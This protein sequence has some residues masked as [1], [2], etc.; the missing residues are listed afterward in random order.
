MAAISESQIK[1]LIRLLSDDSERIVRTIRDKLIEIGESAV[2]LLL[3]AEI[4][5]PELARRIEQVLDEIRGNRL[6]A[7]MR[8]LAACPTQEVDL[9]AGA[10]LIARYAYPT[11][12]VGLYRRRLDEMAAEI[13]DRMGR[14]VSGEEA[15]K[16]MSR[17]L[18]TEQGFRGNSK[19]YYEADNSYLNRVLDRRTGI[20]IS[21]STVY[22]LVGQRLGLPVYGIGMPGH[23]LVKFDSE[24]YKVFVDCFNAGALLTEKDC[25]RFLIQAGYGFDQ[26][27]LH[28]SSP[29]AI[30]VRTLK[31]LIAIYHKLDEGVKETRLARFMSILDGRQPDECESGG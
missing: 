3:E 6:E 2:P 19:N 18:F 17:Y 24:R 26:K 13:R 7:E 12:D 11:L 8:Q 25:A 1:A 4:E 22:L 10:F 9:E 14:R 30:L 21:L 16:T 23:F 20:P 15:V 27:Y 5:Q 31:N 28:R 29:R